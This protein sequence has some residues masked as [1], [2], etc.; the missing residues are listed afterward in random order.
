[1]FPNPYHVYMHDT[2]SRELFAR[3][4][5]SF[6]SGCIRLERPLELAERLLAGTGQWDRAAIDA[7][8]AGGRTRTV[9]LPRPVPV[10]LTYATAVAER[11]EIYFLPDIYKRD[12]AL[13]R[14]LDAE[15]EFVP[16]AGYEESL[17]RVSSP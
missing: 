6:S 16:P 3:A 11:G 8:I 14:A 4:D 2:P 9:T 10:L 13:L 17:S 7:A 12:P 1:M 5:R 15:F